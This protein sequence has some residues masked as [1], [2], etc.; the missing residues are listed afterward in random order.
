MC[1]LF[2]GSP[3]CPLHPVAA[4]SQRAGEGSRGLPARARSSVTHLAR[5]APV[6]LEQVAH[7]AQEE[8]QAEAAREGGEGRRG[9]AGSVKG[10]LLEA[11]PP[12]PSP[13]AG[14]QLPNSKHAGLGAVRGAAREEGREARV[15]AP[16]PPAPPAALPHSQH[17]GDERGGEGG[18]HLPRCTVCSRGWPFRRIL[19]SHSSWRQLRHSHTRA[20][21]VYYSAIQWPPQPGPANFWSG[22]HSPHSHTTPNKAAPHEPQ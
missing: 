15:R 20:Q 17:E 22:E 1:F 18:L 5:R 14:T 7:P 4:T 8:Y 21:R 10:G 12:W 3:G 19:A 16:A 13:L 11:S 9:K 2:A 6:S